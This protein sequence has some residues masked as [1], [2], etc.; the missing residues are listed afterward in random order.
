[1]TEASKVHDNT[2]DK[3]RDNQIEIFNLSKEF[4]KEEKLEK[5]K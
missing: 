4:E 3:S 1:M 5:A 2:I